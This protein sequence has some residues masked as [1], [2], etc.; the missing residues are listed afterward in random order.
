MF[1]FTFAASKLMRLMLAF[2]VGG[3]LGD[4]FLHLLPEAWSKSHTV[5]DNLILGL[6]VVIGLFSFTSLEVFFS[7]KDESTDESAL[8]TSSS[9]SSSSSNNNKS[10]SHTVCPITGYLNVIANG[11]DNF[12][13]GLAVAGSFMAGYKIGM[14][15]TF[16]IIIHEVPHEFGDFAILMKSGFSKREAAKA[17]ISTASFGL[18]GALTALMFDSIGTRTYWILPFTAGGF[19]HISLVDILP[20]IVNEDNPV[21]SIK[22]LF[23]VA[24]GIGVMALVNMFIH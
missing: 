10:T 21:E 15:T 1:S 8:I 9:S 3:L 23:A 11:I 22:Q 13:H 19:L 18:L 24:S 4:V 5:A 2:A 17:Q 12:T 16:A 6:W 14:L 20:D 7:V